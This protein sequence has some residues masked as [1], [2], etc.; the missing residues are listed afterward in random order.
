MA[1]SKRTN[2]DLAMLTSAVLTVI[3]LFGARALYG[4]YADLTGK[5]ALHDGSGPVQSMKAQQR[6][7]LARGPLAIGDAM[8]R[9]AEAD[10]RSIP[11]IAPESS[12]DTA[13][14]AGW[15]HGHRYVAPPAPLPEE[16]APVLEEVPPVEG[17]EGTEAAAP[18]PAPEAA[19]A[20]AAR[21]AAPV[22]PAAAAAPA[23]AA[24]PAAPAAPAARPAAPAA[25]A[26][27][28]AAPS[29]AAPP[30]AP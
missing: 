15:M 26:A 5:H 19:A 6:E 2:Q 28:P 27:R 29:P 20:P 21:P 25:P 8:A 11:L 12:F 9:L 22:A 23:P 30:A 18:T 4:Y 14:A 17:A 13:P 1:E 7:Q 16:P 3:L 24:R 10:R